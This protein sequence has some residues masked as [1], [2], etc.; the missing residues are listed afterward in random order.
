VSR[1][2][3]LPLFSSPPH[4]ENSRGWEWMGACGRSGMHVCHRSQPDNNHACPI[5]C[6]RFCVRPQVLLPLRLVSQSSTQVGS[7]A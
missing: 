7:H 3:S 6:Y 2:A 5:V 4:P 1:E